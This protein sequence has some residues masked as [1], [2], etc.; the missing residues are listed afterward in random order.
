MEEEM[1]G[2]ILSGSRTVKGVDS[3]KNIDAFD[4][5]QI[6]RIVGR[7]ISAFAAIRTGT[8]IIQ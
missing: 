3:K 8:E 6:I 1:L 2:R 4:D 7:K 5:G